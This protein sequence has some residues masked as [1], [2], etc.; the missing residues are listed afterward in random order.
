[1]KPLQL[2]VCFCLLSSVLASAQEASDPGNWPQFRGANAT[3]VASDNPK[4]PETWSETENVEWKSDLPGRGWSSP[5]VWGDRVFLT[6][7]VNEGESEEPKKGLYFGGNRPKPPSSQHSWRVIC[8]NLSDGSTRWEKS[9]R[10]AAPQ[11]SIHIKNSFASETPVTDGK[12]LYVVF[13]GMGVYCFD[14]KGNQVWNRDLPPSKTRYGWGTAASPVLH[15]D[16]LYILHDNEEDSY[17]LALDKNT[18]DEVWR[19]VREEKSNWATPY[20]WKTKDRAEIVTPGTGRV[21]SYD[22]AGN[23]LWSF[24]GMSS[25]TIATPYEYEGLLIIS[26]GYV[27]DKSRPLYAIR[28]GAN[29]DIS[30]AKGETKNEFVAWCQPQGGPY[31]P[32]TITYKGILYVLHDR[33]FMNAF[34]A[35]TGTEVYDR[36]RVAG[37]S[38]FTS[39][40]W[41]Y[42]DK[43][44]CLSEDG[45]TFVVKAGKDFEV[46]GKNEL[47]AEDMGMATPAIAS[48]RLLIRTAARI[49]SIKKK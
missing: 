12:H 27:G 35:K 43:L 46:L 8:L 15:E 31:N 33:G 22:L 29:G 36:R 14:L 49:Y 17:L 20:V 34:D 45:S 6:T 10:S 37:V 4:L 11:T 42:N 13:G 39:S 7:V 19:K 30:L 1:M 3:G 16:R 23:E 18:G 25:I 47:A 21:R 9:V 5:V 32:S 38:G 48:E 41:A 2:L 40:P 24:K 28:P 26:S 44:F